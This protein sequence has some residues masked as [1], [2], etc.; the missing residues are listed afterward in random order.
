MPRRACRIAPALAAGAC[1]CLTG[2]PAGLAGG[3]PILALWF[4]AP[5]IAW[6]ISQPMDA[7]SELTG[8]TR[9]LHGAARKTWRFFETFV[10]AED[11]WLPPDNFQ[12]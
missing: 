5:S 7:A 11:H 1:A 12:E 3:A 9:F 4:G 6:R 10:G 8:A 2:A